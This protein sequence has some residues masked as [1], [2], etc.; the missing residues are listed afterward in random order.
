MK[1]L[2]TATTAALAAEET[3]SCWLLQMSLDSTYY[4]TNSD[5]DIVWDGNTY[6]S[7]GFE[8]KDINANYQ[9]SADIATI[10]V[11]NADKT[12]SAI[13]LGEDV[14]NKTVICNLAL[15]DTTAK[16]PSTVAELMRGY[17]T[18]WDLDENS[19]KIEL[20]S[21]FMLWGKKTLRLP[22]PN[23]P[24][25][26]KGTEC[27]YSGATTWCDKSPEQCSNLGNSTNFGGRKFINDIE[28]KPIYWGPAGY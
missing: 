12:M 13:L 20:G 25:S 8:I 6:V 9:F 3:A 27:G 26:F 14:A 19:A 28:G 18:S 23:C 24:W 4:Y 22:T 16:R 21:E 7:K 15:I 17:I 1:S 10:E 5:V 2:T 11:D